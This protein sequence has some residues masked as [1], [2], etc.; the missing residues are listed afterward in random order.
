MGL[1]PHAAKGY[2][3]HAGCGR[4]REEIP[5]EPP[6]GTG[7]V[8]SGSPIR[9]ETGAAVDLRRRATADHPAHPGGGAGNRRP[10]RLGGRQAEQ[11]EDLVPTA[12]RKALKQ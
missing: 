9:G 5:G 2:G 1:R 4:V 8:V 11:P 6:L 7:R 3:R 10:R 12:R